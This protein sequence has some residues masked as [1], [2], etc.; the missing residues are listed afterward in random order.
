MEP[1]P[2]PMDSTAT[3]GWRKGRPPSERLLEMCASPSK[4]RQTSVVVPP[5]SKLM[6]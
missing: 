3:M 2:A 4:I 5:M 1:P 6:A